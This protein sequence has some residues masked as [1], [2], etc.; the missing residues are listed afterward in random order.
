MISGS[1]SAAATPDQTARG[2]RVW[3]LAGP[4]SAHR[5]VHDDVVLDPRLHVFLR[6][7]VQPLCDRLEIGAV[8]IEESQH[9]VHLH[10]RRGHSAAEV[11]RRGAHGVTYE[12]QPLGERSACVVELAPVVVEQV[13]AGSTGVI[14]LDRSG[15][16]HSARTGTA[17]HAA[18]NTASSRAAPAPG[19]SCDAP[20]ERSR[21][22]AR[23]GTRS[24]GSR[25]GH[26]PRR[27]G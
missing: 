19:Q 24:P 7:G 5:L 26:R 3:R 8:R 14:G 16:V 20:P 27:S 11:R 17:R 21:S 15:S 13:P 1:A 25:P 22:R 12:E 23:A 2:L 9:L 10:H 18:S 6:P 4:T